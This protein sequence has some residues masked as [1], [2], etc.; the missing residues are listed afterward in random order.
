MD[1]LFVLVLLVL[2]LA[3]F[4][5]KYPALMHQ[6]FSLKP[7]TP[8]V[9]PVKEKGTISTEVSRIHDKARSGEYEDIGDINE[10]LA[11]PVVVLKHEIIRHDFANNLKEYQ[12]RWHCKCGA[13]GYVWVHGSLRPMEQ[14]QRQ[15]RREG[16]EHC[17]EMNKA[18]EILKRTKG[19]FAW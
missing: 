16:Q 9:A 17:V 2:V 18:E 1:G 3:F 8:V 13:S 10:P 6:I 19:N 14:A 4:F 12:P 5:W 7:R 15:A 11:A